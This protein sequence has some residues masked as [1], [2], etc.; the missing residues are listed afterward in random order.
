MM[1]RKTD[2]RRK[3]PNGRQVLVSASI[4]MAGMVG[5]LV[6]FY[7]FD[8]IDI[9]TIIAFLVISIVMIAY[10]IGTIIREGWS[11]EKKK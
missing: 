6:L 2:V 1:S 5:I 8:Q 11:G 3:R 10:T 7:F 4:G 9:V